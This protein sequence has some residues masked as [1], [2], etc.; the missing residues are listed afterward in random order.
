MQVLLIDAYSITKQGRNAFNVFKKECLKALSGGWDEKHDIQERR[1]DSLHDYVCEWYCFVVDQSSW[2]ARLLDFT[3]LRRLPFCGVRGDDI[4]PGARGAVDSGARAQALGA[5]PRALPLGGV[6]RE[7]R[8]VPR[9][10]RG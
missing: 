8:G 1:I 3:S 9:A 2:I 7:L 4:L 10:V 6:P 5:A